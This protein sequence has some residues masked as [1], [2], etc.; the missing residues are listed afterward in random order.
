[1]LH[2]RSREPPSRGGVL[3][4]RPL[5]LRLDAGPA[6]PAGRLPGSGIAVPIAHRASPFDFTAGE[7]AALHD[8]LVQAKEAWDARLAPDGY[9]L[10]WTCFPPS[11]DDVRTMHAHLHV[12]S[13]LR[14]RA[15]PRSRRPHCD[16]V[17]RQP[18]PGPVRAGHRPCA[19]VRAVARVSRPPCGGGGRSS[20]RRGSLRCARAS[21]PIGRSPRGCSGPRDRRARPKRGTRRAR[22]PA[23]AATRASGSSQTS[24]KTASVIDVLTVPGE[25]ANTRTPCAACLGRERFG[26]TG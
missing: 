6:R 12:R 1:M 9:F 19:A 10:S 5:R 25:I 18:A 26:Q 4:E 23:R 8:V 7:W 20:R 2:V 14:R 22:P 3:R 15:V 24:A 11:D 16:Q 13:S 21:T 17:A